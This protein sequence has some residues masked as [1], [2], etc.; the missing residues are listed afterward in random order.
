MRR[1]VGLVKRA[2]HSLARPIRNTFPSLYAAP[3]ERQRLPELQGRPIDFGPAILLS[4]NPPIFLSGMPYDEFLGIAPT[5]ARRYG[6]AKAGFIVYPTWSIESEEKARYISY[7]ASRH[8]RL[9]PNHR[10]RFICNTQRETELLNRFGR[11]AL[12]LN[13]KFT[14]SEEVFRPLD[15]VSVTFDAIYN[16]RFVAGKRHELAAGINNVAYVTYAEPQ[17]TRQDDFRRLWAETAARNPGHVLLNPLKHGL[18]ETLSHAEVNQCLAKATTGLLLSEVEGA[19]YAAVEYMLAGLSVVSTPSQGGRDVFFD[20]DYCAV[21]EPDPRTIRD[22]VAGLKARNI[23]RHEIR[24]RTL[25][26]I[27]PERRRFL[28]LVDGMREEL[29]ERRRFVA[30]TWPFAAV[31]GVPWNGFKHHIAAMEQ[32]QRRAFAGEIGM[33]PQS[34]DD[35]QLTVTELRPIVQ[36]LRARPGASLLVFGCGNDSQLWERLNSGGTTTFLEDDPDWAST[37]QSKLAASAVHLVTYGT[38]LSDWSRLLPR[39]EALE[40]DLPAD[41]TGRKWDIILVDGPAGHKDDCPGRM[42]SIY[43]ASRLVAPGGMIFLHDAER[44]AEAA[45]ADRYLKRG[46]VV[47]DV[48]ARAGLKGYEF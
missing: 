15:D 34:L 7:L 3:F 5:F 37:V 32:A 25:K 42:K 19:S 4:E 18:P 36:A 2:G 6:N 30:N 33:D 1:V 24:A 28:D 47:V 26:R 11:P 9:Y 44:P 41:V 46:R 10:L 22:A 38:R 23:P 8:E 40:M 20:P 12:F 45:Y 31:S 13:H 43:A 27:E 16:A 21:V 35:V 17:Q 48:R 14:V 29:G 39:P